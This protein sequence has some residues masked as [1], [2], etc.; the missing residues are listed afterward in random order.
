MNELSS[1]IDV[2]ID[3][4]LPE[5]GGRSFNLNINLHLPG[6]G[7]T[8][9]FGESGSGKTTLLRCIAGLENDPSAEVIVFSIISL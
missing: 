1:T 5:Y 2:K 9:V 6:R 8:A 3:H 7:V 4:Q